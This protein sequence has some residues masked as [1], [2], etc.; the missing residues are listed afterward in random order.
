MAY[1]LKNVAHIFQDLLQKNKLEFYLKLIFYI[2][3]IA[4]L[5]WFVLNYS[6]NVPIGDHY[7]L[8]GLFEKI[9]Q[10]T[11]DFKDFFLQ[12]NEHR[13]FF[14]KIIFSILA[15]TS[16]W[17]VKFEVYLGI[18]ITIVSFYL[19]YKIADHSQEHTKKNIFHL[20]NILTCFYIFS[21]TQMENWLWGFQLA[22][23]LINAFV[24]L[25]IFILTVPKKIPPN[26]KLLSSAFCCLIASFSMAHGLFSW[27]AIIPSVLSVNGNAKKKKMRLLLWGMMF[28]LCCFVYS[29]GY[30]KSTNSPGILFLFKHPLTTISFFLKLLGTPIIT[31]YAS[32]LIGLIIL[33]SFIV[34]NIYFITNYRSEFSQHAAPW[35]SMGWF[36]IIFALIT[37]LGRVGF[38]IDYAAAPKYTTVTIFLIISCLQMWRLLMSFPLRWSIK[39][40]T[41]F[42]YFI[43]GILIILLLKNYNSLIPGWRLESAVY[44]NGAK[45]CLEVIYYLDES[46]LQQ[47]NL[48]N[49]I[50]FLYRNHLSLE[51][52]RD[53]AQSLEKLR[54]RDFPQDLKFIA[55]PSKIAG[56]ID[57]PSQTTQPLT[58]SNTAT[59]TI[60]GWAMPRED[61]QLPILVLFS[62]G[63]KQSFFASAF[64]KLK[65]PEIKEYYNLS[66]SSGIGWEADIS[67]K[68]LPLG[69]NIIKA[70]VYEQKYKQFVK[71]N[72]EVKVRMIED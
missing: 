55:E 22:W 18:L 47:S 13:I 33:S 46:L 41:K 63:K 37:T 14:P 27:L 28:I 70:W 72:N 68:S 36:A 25:A 26:L 38:G 30:H 66:S 58:L 2:A 9:K 45:T 64:V 56:N 51:N 19:I 32:P 59:L 52:L 48:S 23:F 35:L 43:V 57:L 71:L 60:N 8:I 15:F 10:G 69:D 12:H 54:F 4:L 5:I 17:N 50:W 6:I 21:P 24:V 53:Y 3:P 40:P 49:C 11:A 62:Y 20:F 44:R 29:I 67:L 31:N 42:P 65:R 61:S 16:N 7:D 39:M 34:F 1:I